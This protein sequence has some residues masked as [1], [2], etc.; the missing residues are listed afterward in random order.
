QMRRQGVEET[1]DR[2]AQRLDVRRRPQVAVDCHP[3]ALVGESLWQQ[4]NRL[5]AGPGWV[6]TGLV[7][8]TPAG[9]GRHPD[10]ITGTVERLGDS[11][12]LPRITLHGLRH[13]HIHLFAAGVDA[14]T[15]SARAGH[16]STAFSLDQYAHVLAGRQAVTAAA[17]AAWGRAVMT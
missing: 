6:D 10:T 15:V 17:V 7:F 11:S 14:K 13:T 8:T 3:V 1:P 4:L 5:M 2:R 9:R 12:G 16:S